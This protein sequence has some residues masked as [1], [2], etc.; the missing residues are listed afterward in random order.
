M[1]LHV[2]FAISDRAVK[3]YNRPFYGPTTTWGIRSFYDEVNRADKDNLAYA[4]PEDYELHM[5]GTF[6]DE[7]GRFNQENGPTVIARGK[8]ARGEQP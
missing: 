6:D 2:V 5:L 4:H 1:T 3:A 7:T 8:E